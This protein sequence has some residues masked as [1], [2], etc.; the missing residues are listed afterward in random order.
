MHLMQV[1]LKK[2]KDERLSGSDHHPSNAL[3]GIS[4]VGCKVCGGNALCQ[5]RV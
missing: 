3:H 2:T 1:E 4:L 5:C